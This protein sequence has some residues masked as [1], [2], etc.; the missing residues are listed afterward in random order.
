MMLIPVRFLCITLSRIG[1]GVLVYCLVHSARL[2]SRSSYCFENEVVWL[3][4]DILELLLPD[5]QKH[6]RWDRLLVNAHLATMTDGYGVVRNGAVGITGDRITWVGPVKA[7]PATPEA[8]AHTVRDAAGKWVTPGLIDCHTHLVYAGDR[9]NEFALRQQGKTYKEIAEGGGGILSTVKA[10]R[11]AGEAELLDAAGK[12]LLSFLRE[13][14]T[15]IEVKSGYGLD[16]ENE[17]KLLR[18]A[19]TLEERYPVTVKTTFLAAHCVP[20]E[21]KGDADGY[22]EAV[23][24]AMLPAV[25][26]AGLA[27]A[28]DGFCEHIGF[29]PAQITRLFDAASALGLP[30][31]LHA[32]QLS[33]TGGAALAA[34]YKALSAD[35]LE[36][37]SD[38]GVKAMARAGTVAVLL[39][40][41]FYMLN[42]TQKPPVAA[43]RKAGVPIALAS[44]CNP[45]T[46]PVL[47]LLL[48]L[49]M[50]CVLFNLTP[51]EALAGVTRHAAAALG[52]AGEA[53]QIKAG[54]VADLALW[55]IAHPD[56]LAYYAGGSPCI[57]V[58]KHGIFE[59]YHG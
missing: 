54:M 33:D 31:K 29:T 11:A 21:F 4:A 37:A 45:G 24:T 39:P 5:N 20:P 53:G 43:L 22:M 28:V 8:L 52:M 46:S 42:E 3:L 58:I 27:D 30:V 47:S 32:E 36:Y 40:G 26:K 14:V 50:G 56:A 6:E 55:D 34:K 13:G 2:A 51:E 10:T 15:T 35:H 44:D 41:A 19:R 1:L 48:V 17:M 38:A 16:L 23:C 59:G 25:A 18:V 49:N 12:R 57:G 7:L 9:A